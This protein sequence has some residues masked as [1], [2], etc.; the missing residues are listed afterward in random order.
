[1]TEARIARIGDW[2]FDARLNQLSQGPTVVTLEPL[3]ARVL[4]YLA[5]RQG[6]VV[7]VDELVEALWNRRFVG[8]NPVYRVLAELR[9]ALGDS[10]QYPKYIQTIRKSGYRLIAT[11]ELQS[12][13]EGMP[14]STA[15]RAPRFGIAAL[16][17]AL[18]AAIALAWFLST[19]ETTVVEEP[20]KPVVAI[21]P[22]D[23]MSEDG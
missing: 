20:G 22:F 18:A 16:V 23:D 3:A 8:D 6:E 10:A 14:A 15:T 12:P 21:M 13:R 1:M 2:T 5:E 9:R 4:S 19:R 11:V 7:S 17:L